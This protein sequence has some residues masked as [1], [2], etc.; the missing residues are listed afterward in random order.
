MVAGGP[1]SSQNP[2]ALHTEHAQ[3]EHAGI[4]V[5]SSEEATDLAEG[6]PKR[7]VV[8]H[9]CVDGPQRERDEEAEVS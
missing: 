6:L 9:R 1:A 8:A 2:V 5:K 3:T 7:P 4:H